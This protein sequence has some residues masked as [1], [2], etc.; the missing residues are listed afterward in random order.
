MSTRSIPASG[1]A[2]LPGVLMFVG[3][4]V[5]LLFLYTGV[6]KWS[7]LAGFERIVISHGLIGVQNAGPAA[8]ALATAEIGIGALGL[9]LILIKGFRSLAPVFVLQAALFLLFA[10]YASFVVARP[11]PDPTTCGCGVFSAPTA[12]WSSILTR[13]SATAGALGLAS[14]VVVRVRPGRAAVPTEDEPLVR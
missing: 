2:L 4:G 9:L 7:N 10:G 13:N 8:T 12:D 11:P 6:D 3:L 1:R 5:S 14:L